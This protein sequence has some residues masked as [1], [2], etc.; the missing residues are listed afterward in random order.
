MDE[1]KR[2]QQ[3]LIET[4]KT[5]RKQ[6]GMS[7]E[8]IADRAKISRQIIGKIENGKTNPTMLMMFKIMQAM[9][10]EFDVFVGMVLGKDR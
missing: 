2:F 3:S 9:D 7:H 10:F 4:F 1:N 5:V 8:Y 6:Q